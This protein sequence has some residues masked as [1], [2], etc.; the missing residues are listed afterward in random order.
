MVD[1]GTI[2]GRSCA[3]SGRCKLR[4]A[5]LIAQNF[6]APAS[7]ASP[8]FCQIRCACDKKRGRSGLQSA[9]DELI[10]KAAIHH[11]RIVGCLRPELGEF[12]QSSWAGR[13]AI[14]PSCRGP[15]MMLPNPRSLPHGLT[16]WVIMAQQS[17]RH[18]HGRPRHDLGT[19]LC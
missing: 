18:D 13:P 11:R 14:A 10:D 15:S 4:C 12:I 1:H 17:D 2:W 19:K 5:C 8:N 9:C 3:N 7:V 16:H 6:A